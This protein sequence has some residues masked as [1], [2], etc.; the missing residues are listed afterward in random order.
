LTLHHQHGTHR[1][2]RGR[3][4]LTQPGPHPQA[5]VLPLQAAG[6]TIELAFLSDW[7]QAAPRCAF[8]A[9]AGKAATPTMSA[10]AAK[11]I[12]SFRIT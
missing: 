1:Q 7:R 2:Q 6:W 5:P 12:D 11:V 9:L 4:A 8:C 3:Q 10:A